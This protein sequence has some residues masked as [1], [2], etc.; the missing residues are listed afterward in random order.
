MLFPTQ[1]VACCLE[2]TFSSLYNK[3]LVST[4]GF[5][6]PE[7]EN[8]TFQKRCRRVNPRPGGGLSHLRSGGGGEGGGQDDH[9]S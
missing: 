4:V 6:L 5:G 7:V 2:Q 9:T 1:A 3:T 8:E